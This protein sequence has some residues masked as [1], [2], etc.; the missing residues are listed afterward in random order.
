MFSNNVIKVYIEKI[1][2]D[3]RRIRIE[4]WWII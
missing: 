1:D 4:K 2:N 3:S